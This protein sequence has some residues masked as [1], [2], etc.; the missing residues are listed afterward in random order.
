[1]E[2]IF[3]SKHTRPPN[4]NLSA[5]KT[6]NSPFP[7]LSCLHYNLPPKGL[8]TPWTMKSSQG[9]V[10]SAIGCWIRPGTTLVDTKEIINVWV[11]MEFAV[12]KSYIWRPTLSIDMVHRV[13]WWQR[14]KRWSGRKRHNPMANKWYYNNYL[15]KGFFGGRED[16]E[17]SIQ[18]ND[19]TC[20]YFYFFK[21][22]LFE[23][24]I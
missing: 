22:I 1:M 16:E 7:L 15:I 11:T 19:R 17:K 4:Q 6:W 8:V 5:N 2:V 12:P 21:N 14:H 10:K 23:A 9:H 20:F 18:E 13:W 24:Y 3:Y